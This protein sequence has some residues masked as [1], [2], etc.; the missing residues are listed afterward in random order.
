M[1][2]Q[3]VVEYEIDVCVVLGCSNVS[4]NYVMQ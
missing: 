1:Y 3:Y 2:Y 4:E